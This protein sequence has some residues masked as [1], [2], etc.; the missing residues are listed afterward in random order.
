MTDKNISRFSSIEDFMTHLENAPLGEGWKGSQSSQDSSYGFTG[1]HS[2]SEAIGLVKNG[3]K[4]GAEQIKKGLDMIKS[5]GQSREL[6]YDIA[7]ERPSVVRA[8]AGMPDSMIRKIP[9]QGKRQ[10]IIS[11]LVNVGGIG[12]VESYAMKNRAIAIAS[13]ID[14]LESVGFSVEL[15]CIWYNTSSKYKDGF[16]GITFP[17]KHAGQPMD[18]SNIAFFMGHPSFLRRLLFSWVE[19]LGSRAELSGYGSSTDITDF[20]HEDIYFPC[21]NALQR[22]AGNVPDAIKYIKG[23]IINKRP[24]LFAEDIAA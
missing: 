14:E 21:N 15:N 3:W 23:I 19:T 4:D 12:S 18:I 10:P 2:Y 5:Y 16:F 1:T 22:V 20:G 13:V 7:G 17:I 8:I 6:I 24:D 9:A 11:L